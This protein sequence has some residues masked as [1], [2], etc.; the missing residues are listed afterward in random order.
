[1]PAASAA[2][3]L[4]DEALWAKVT[5]EPV[6]GRVYSLADAIIFLAE[7][8]MALLG[9]W[10][11]TALGPIP[12]LAIIGGVVVLGAAG[13]SA[14]SRGYKDIAGLALGDRDPL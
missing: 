11:V 2:F 14:S 7:V 4:I 6:R 13:L 8:G 1:L 5:P 12:A 3:W 10:L 9:G